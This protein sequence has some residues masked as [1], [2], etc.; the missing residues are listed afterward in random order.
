MRNLLQK[1][2]KWQWLVCLAVGCCFSSCK[3][4]EESTSGYDPNKPIVL[5]DFYPP[6]G[7]LATQV[8]LNGSN[9]GDSKE[10]VKVFFNDKEASVISVKDDRMLVLAPKRASTIEDPECVVKVQVHEQIEEYKQTFDYY[11]QTTVTTLVGGSTSAQVNPTGTIP[12][13]EAQFRANIDRC[14]CVDQDK[15]VFFLVDN[16]GKFAAF[17]LNEEADKLISLKSDI[18][19]LFNSPVLGYNSKDDIV[20]QFWANRDSHEVY[21]FDPKT[22]YAPT[23]AISSISWDDPNFPNIEGFGVWAA[24]CNFT[25][26]PD[27]KM[28]SR[29]LGG[30]LVRID[31]ENARGENLTN[32]V[33]QVVHALDVVA[34]ASAEYL[35]V[36]RFIEHT[37]AR[38]QLFYQLVIEHDIIDIDDLR[39]DLVGSFR[40]F[41]N[42]QNIMRYFCFHTPCHTFP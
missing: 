34:D 26:G 29:M 21:Y 30:N 40:H 27:G 13:S 41:R 3:D 17:M 1:C 2:F 6:E 8:I 5:T 28:Y 14:I 23:T 22:D 19:A 7:K 33:L 10:N 4:D 12:L 37:L 20:Y 15:N 38:A 39:A 25:M 36:C 32:G 31:V 35:H 42:G 11:I 16:D 18:N 9:F 24:K